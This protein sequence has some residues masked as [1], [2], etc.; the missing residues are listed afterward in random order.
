MTAF[1]ERTE[2]RHLVVLAAAMLAGAQSASACTLL[3]PRGETIGY[4]TANG[5]VL[6][7]EAG[8][9][10]QVS[11][12]GTVFDRGHAVVGSVSTDGTIFD[13]EMETLGHISTDGTVLDKNAERK[14]K[15]YGGCDFGQLGAA[16]I[17]LTP[18]ASPRR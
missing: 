16:F 13:A 8:E 6:R 3:N 5:T 7:S 17:L 4:V 18:D 1:L 2:V 11:T 10:G 9:V 15:S 12:N 14:L